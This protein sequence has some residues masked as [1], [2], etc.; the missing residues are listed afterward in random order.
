MGWVQSSLR[1]DIPQQMDRW[2]G[3]LLRPLSTIGLRSCYLITTG[4]WSSLLRLRL[5]LRYVKCPLLVPVPPFLICTLQITSFLSK[6]RANHPMNYALNLIELIVFN[7]LM[8]FVKFNSS[9]NYKG[10]YS[11][12]FYLI[13]LLMY[14]TKFMVFEQTC[15]GWL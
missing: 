14:Q 6:K 5:R 2:I 7:Y 1:D 8:I 3:C 9:V 13:Y 4:T 15:E 12:A 11:K 10:I